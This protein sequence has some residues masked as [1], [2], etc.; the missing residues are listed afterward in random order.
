MR[1]YITPA[2]KRHNARIRQSRLPASQVPQTQKSAPSLLPGFIPRPGPAFDM[3]RAESAE[4]SRPAPDDH[5]QSSE[6]K[7]RR[8]K[9]SSQTATEGEDAEE[10]RR[11]LPAPRFVPVHRGADLC[12]PASPPRS[13]SSRGK[14]TTPPRLSR[15]E[16]PRFSFAQQ[17]S[18]SDR[19]PTGSH[20]HRRSDTSPWQD[21]TSVPAA[22]S[23]LSADPT[24]P[25]PAPIPRFSLDGLLSMDLTGARRA[26]TRSACLKAISTE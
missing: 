24:A 21:Q 8:R 20:S 23:A 13:R 25:P 5:T 12:A 1:N 7:R 16:R 6:L 4:P 2:R 17:L 19:S 11:R 3:R 9:E 26:R 10:G 22:L 18:P 14:P 15:G